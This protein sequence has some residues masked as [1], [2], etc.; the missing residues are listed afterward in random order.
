MEHATMMTPEEL[1]KH[2]LENNLKL[3]GDVPYP[4][5][6]GSGQLGTQGWTGWLPKDTPLYETRKQ[7]NKRLFSMEI[8][9]EK[10]TRW[11]YRGEQ[12]AEEVVQ[13]RDVPGTIQHRMWMLYQGENPDVLPPPSGNGK[14]YEPPKGDF[15]E[16][17]QKDDE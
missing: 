4:R 16:Q 17:E 15:Y 13:L 14:I 11:F 12:P 8:I 2:M 3:S 6:P 7:Q 1:R 5:P 9:W 10:I